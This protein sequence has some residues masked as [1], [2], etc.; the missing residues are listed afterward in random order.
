M[1][2]T[3]GVGEGN[4]DDDSCRRS[5][6]RL[7]SF[8]AAASSS[9]V[10]LVDDI[11]RQ[12]VR[13]QHMSTEE[14]TLGGYRSEGEPW[15]EVVPQVILVAHGP[16]TSPLQYLSTPLINGQKVPLDNIKRFV[17]HSLH[18][19]GGFAS[20]LRCV[21][22]QPELDCE[23][24]RGLGFA[25][26]DAAE[27]IRKLEE[28]SIS[29][30]AV[31]VPTFG[32][33][34]ESAIRTVTEVHKNEHL[35]SIVVVMIIPYI[36]CS[37]IS[38]ITEAACNQETRN[39]V[40]AASASDPSACLQ[41]A[42][43][44]TAAREALLEIGADDVIC[45]FAGEP[46][47]PHR[48]LESVETTTVMAKRAE[49]MIERYI[50]DISEQQT[51]KMQST[52]KK[53]LM[54]M[55]GRVLESLPFEDSSIKEEMDGS[56]NLAK[57]ADY[58]VAE[59]VYAGTFG[60]IHCALHPEHGTC[61]LRTVA[62]AQH[63][64]R[65][66]DFIR[67]DREISIMLH[68]APHPHIVRA[69]VAFHTAK[70]FHCVLDYAGSRHLQAFTKQY[71]QQNGGG[72]LPRNVVSSF[73]N[74][75]ASAVH[76]LHGA[77]VCNRD[78][79]TDAWLVS[80]CDKVLRLA[81]F[82][83]AAQVVGKTQE[84]KEACGSLPFCAP[85]VVQRSVSTA[86]QPGGYDG[87]AA[88]VWSLGVGFFEMVCGPF[89]IERIL[90][91]IP[92]QPD[93]LEERLR[94]LESLPRCWA[95]V[96][97]DDEVPYDLGYCVS[98]ML[99]LSPASRWTMEVLTGP[100]GLALR[101]FAARTESQSALPAQRATTTPRNVQAID[102]DSDVS[103]ND[104]GEAPLSLQLGGAVAML[105]AM[106]RALDRFL[107]APGFG[108]AYSSR[109]QRLP[110]IRRFYRRALLGLVDSA[111]GD[112]KEQTVRSEARDVHCGLFV[113]HS[114]FFLIAE[115]IRDALIC[116]GAHKNDVNEVLH[117]FVCL[118]NDVVECCG[119]QV[120]FSVERNTPLWRRGVLAVLRKTALRSFAEALVAGIKASD[121]LVSGECF[122]QWTPELIEGHFMEYLG[123]GGNAN[124]GRT[125]CGGGNE[126][127]G[128]TPVSAAAAAAGRPVP[129]VFWEDG[130]SKPPAG[131]PGHLELLEILREALEGC[132]PWALEMA[133]T[134]YLDMLEEWER[135]VFARHKGKTPAEIAAAANGAR[136]DR[137]TRCSLPAAPVM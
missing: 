136:S 134:L 58:T 68:V 94:G 6:E 13:S 76:H 29:E 4:L 124:A 95:Q 25:S 127:A 26:V 93:E 86:P 120:S 104:Y 60:R 52:F 41:L 5:L 117:R 83:L 82:C 55:P 12:D 91:W 59:K 67:L 105:M 78:L 38:S 15:Q 96:A 24:L 89:S 118:R 90:G 27:S 44:V 77:L 87:F 39:S 103:W 128:G 79:K 56:G 9:A 64:K 17:C 2:S 51:R 137:T 110:G 99:I 81:D 121:Y 66:S 36:G 71:L 31:V 109:P 69:R 122:Q 34:V 62:K 7:P 49:Q 37:N 16:P 135:A 80:D 75:Q 116:Q 123:S 22:S 21:P 10:L 114:H 50:Q 61:M 126:S 65:I 133:R 132:A 72:V 85:E 112:S 28:G 101:G 1:S 47:R 33:D 92:Q 20:E 100:A 73:I 8:P 115:Y 129:L 130:S 35:P 40:L 32:L 54:A 53:F 97:Q 3:D 74:Q 113:R 23:E 14:L 11:G 46:L 57:V 119:L 43:S 102:L 125:E 45:L 108:R 98:H 19:L 106:E 70:N 111:P 30:A 18:G 84:L 107:A 88:D 131:S 48:L 42:R 63:L